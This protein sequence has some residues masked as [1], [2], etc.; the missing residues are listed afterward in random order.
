MIMNAASVALRRGVHFPNCISCKFGLICV[1]EEDYAKNTSDAYLLEF[2]R[3][4]IMHHYVG[5]GVR[6]HTEV[7]GV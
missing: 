2:T 6:C 7:D 3:W 1:F 5:M 4:S